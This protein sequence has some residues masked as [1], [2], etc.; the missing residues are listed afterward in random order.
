MRVASSFV[1][2]LTL[3]VSCSTS[4]QGTN[5]IDSATVPPP[6]S[7]TNPIDGGIVPEPIGDPTPGTSTGDHNIIHDSIDDPTPTTCTG[8]IDRAGNLACDQAVLDCMGTFN[9]GNIYLCTA[10][11]KYCSKHNWNAWCATEVFADCHNICTIKCLN[12]SVKNYCSFEEYQCR[13][14]CQQ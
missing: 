8:C 2:V 9:S 5:H 3:L 1:I 14:P 13:E 4:D 7:S 6:T 11:K 10:D 12:C